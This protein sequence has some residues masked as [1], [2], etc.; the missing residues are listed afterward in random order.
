MSMYTVE[1]DAALQVEIEAKSKESAKC[2]ITEMLD[3]ISE[4]YGIDFKYRFTLVV[5]SDD[6]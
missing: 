4:I 2:Y 5:D 3:E 6:E 1:L